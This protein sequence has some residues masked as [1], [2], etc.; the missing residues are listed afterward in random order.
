MVSETPSFAD[1]V[2]GSLLLFP[3]PVKSAGNSLSTI[4]G[5]EVA[6]FVLEGSKVALNPYSGAFSSL[7]CWLNHTLEVSR[8]GH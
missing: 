7:K 1:T 8:V 2:L 3:I 4:K 6:S 5:V